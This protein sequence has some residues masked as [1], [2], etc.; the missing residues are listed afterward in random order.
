[1]PYIGLVAVLAARDAAARVI[2][3]VGKF[4]RQNKGAVMTNKVSATDHEAKTADYLPLSRQAQRETGSATQTLGAI[5]RMTDMGV[6]ASTFASYARI[7]ELSRLPESVTKRHISNLVAQG[8]L[9]NDGRELLKGSRYMRRRTN[10]IRLSR[11]AIEHRRPFNPLPCWAIEFLTSWSLRAVYAAVVARHMLIETV[12][13]AEHGEAY[14]REEM[15]LKNLMDETGLNK[16]AAIRAKKVLAAMGMITIE[17]AAAHGVGDLISL[18]PNFVVPKSLL[19]RPPIASNK[20][21][22]SGSDGGSNISSY[23]PSN[24]SD[25]TQSHFGLGVVTNWSSSLWRTYYQR[26]SIEKGPMDNLAS[27]AISDLSNRSFPYLEAKAIFDRLVASYGV[28]PT[29]KQENSELRQIAILVSASLLPECHV[30]SAAQGVKLCSP[31]KPFGY[32]FKCLRE[33]C[34]KAGIDLRALERTK[35]QPVCEGAA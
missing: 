24:I 7:S 22:P 12:A 5:T 35:L 4:P 3:R 13:A 25:P 27:E 15:S 23:T 20:S 6:T 28:Q 34:S 10:T 1:M 18:N 26:T 17:G 16:P 32:F 2:S 29:S 9:V 21:N 11:Y 14:G 19:A 33:D 31:S 30:W 8:W